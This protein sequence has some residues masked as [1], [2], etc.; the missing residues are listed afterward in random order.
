MK[1]FHLIKSLVNRALSFNDLFL[2]H[3]NKMVRLNVNIIT[4][5]IRLE[6]FFFLSQ[7]LK[8]VKGEAVLIVMYAI[9][10]TLT[11]I[12]NNLSPFEYLFGSHLDYS[13][14][15]PFECVY[16]VLL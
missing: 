9:N 14:F 7:V 11:L 15:K 10:H 2:V 3:L 6:L 13:I 16:F 1:I 4:Y 5:L 8:N 12:L